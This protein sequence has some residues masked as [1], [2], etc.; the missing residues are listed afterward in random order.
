M[1]TLMSKTAQM[2]DGFR[3]SEPYRRWT[4]EYCGLM[5]RKGRQRKA[6]EIAAWCWRGGGFETNKAYQSGA[7]HHLPAGNAGLDK[8]EDWDTAI[9]LGTREDNIE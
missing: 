1:P 2:M 5:R 4:R 8:K 9:E 3:N 7:V 6:A